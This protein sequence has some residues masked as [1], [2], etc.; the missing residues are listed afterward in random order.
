MK[1]CWVTDN[2]SVIIIII[3]TIQDNVECEERKEREM[4]K[5]MWFKI[6]FDFDG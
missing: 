5:W 1:I 2:L 6:T 4:I 3:I